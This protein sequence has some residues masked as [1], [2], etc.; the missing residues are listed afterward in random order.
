[1]DGPTIGHMER[2]FDDQ[3]RLS[4]WTTANGATPSFGYDEAGA[5]QYETNSVGV[6]S[7]YTYDLAGRLIA[8]TNLATGAG[9]TYDYDAAGQRVGV[10][11]AAGEWTRYGYH[12]DGSLAAMTNALGRY[13]LYT[14]DVAGSCCG[15]SARVTDPF[16][17][18]VIN[19]TSPLGLPLETI[20]QAGAVS[21]T[22][23]TTYLAGLT[24][25]EQEAQEYP[26]TVTDEGGRVR[27]FAYTDLGQLERATDLSGVTWWTNHYD[28][29]TGALTN[30]L[31]PTG[32]T[33]SYT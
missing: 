30:I 33:L 10:T 32:E 7:Q 17:R 18:Q 3:N 31:S 26:E 5:L 13:W 1:M 9:A 4:G 20:R 21:R 27:R 23:K 14:N 29:D 8:V 12:E 11:N 22:N 15:A 25:E 19:I 6:V 2:R 24:T 28:P 16:G